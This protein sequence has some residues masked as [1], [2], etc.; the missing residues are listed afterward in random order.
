[1]R[2]L[3]YVD[4]KAVI[5]QANTK[6]ELERKGASTVAVL[7]EWSK[8]V[9]LK[10]APD[11]THLM[12]LKGSLNMRSPPVIRIDGFTIKAPP[13][14][15]YLGVKMTAQLRFRANAHY[16]CV[17][18]PATIA[19]IRAVSGPTWGTSYRTRRIYYK[20]LSESVMLYAAPAWTHSLGAVDWRVL[21]RA[22]RSALLAVTQAYRTVSTDALQ[23]IAG[24]RAL[25]A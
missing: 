24:C 2:R 21:E 14:L 11:K 16:I 4:D 7:S 10:L 5:I 19:S 18:I 3:V 1:M 6:A 13:T 20:A 17:K 8:R 25:L 23:I 9:K 12:L 22:Q 15:T